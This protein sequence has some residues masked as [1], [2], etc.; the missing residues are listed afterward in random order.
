MKH[1][2]LFLALI[3]LSIPAFAQEKEGAGAVKADPADA[4]ERLA[5]AEKMHDVWPI[6]TRMEGAIDRV[7]EAFPPERHAEIRAI[8]RKSMK[9]DE[10][11]EES[12][13]A[14][15]SVFTADELKAMIEFYG[16]DVGR[17]VSAKTADYEA[18]IA[19]VLTQMM[20]KAMMDLRLGQEGGI[21]MP[22]AP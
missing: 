5:L 6:R 7:T 13:K 12:I 22:K 15:A 20:D 21:P 19:P 17:S 4:V 3:C 2:A 16:S 8:M 9:Y 1:I 11:E 14:M 18:A 10:L